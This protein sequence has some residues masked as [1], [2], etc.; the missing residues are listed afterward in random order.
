MRIITGLALLFL[1][2]LTVATAQDE[3]EVHIAPKL[4]VLKAGV[5]Q[6]VSQLSGE[7]D[8]QGF[9]VEVPDDAKALYVHVFGATSDIDLMLCDARIKHFDELDDHL[10][11]EAMT[12]RFDEVLTWKTDD[13]LAAGKY[14]V[15]AGSLAAYLEEEVSFDILLSFNEPPKVETPKL[16]F[17]AQDTLKPMQRA[18][19]A[20]VMLYT[21]DGAGGTGTVVTPTGLIL[22]NFH[23]IEGEDGEAVEKVWVSLAPSARKLPVQAAIAKIAVTDKALDLALLQIETDL[24]GN[25]FKP[26][27]LVWLPLAKEECELGDDLRCLG[28]P[29]IGGSVS[30]A[31]ITLTRGVVSGFEEKDG[32]LRWYKSDCLLSEGNSG[33][34][35]INDACELAGIPTE[36]LHD[37]TTWEALSYIRPVTALPKVWR[38]R[39]DK[40]LK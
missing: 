30:L 36:T 4:I 28:Y 13:G 23:V 40:E 25:E 10:L 15:Y 38:E 37:P 16:P 34:T 11:V 21:S 39:I 8:L 3:G 24:D 1:F 12:G 31:S 2:S 6:H 9:S 5:K 35:A 27:D 17:A 7:T 32:K 19:A 33:G 22:T 20:S 18:V 26:K 14:V 29:A